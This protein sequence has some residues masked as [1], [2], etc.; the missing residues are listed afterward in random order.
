MAL[1]TIEEIVARRRMCEI[2]E[3]QTEII[4]TLTECFKENGFRW[5]LPVMLSFVTDPLWPE[6]SSTQITAPEVEIYGKKMKLM[7]SMILHKQIAVSMGLDRIFIL[8]PNIRVER[9]ERDDGHHAYEFTQ[10][11]FEI[12]HAKMGDVMHLV[13]EAVCRTASKVRKTVWDRFEREIPVFQRPFK[14]YT[15]EEV[16]KDY[17]S[18]RELSK[19]S[20]QPFWITDISREFYDKEDETRPGH[21]LNYD[22]VMPEGY[23]EVLSGGEREH[24]YE[25]IMTKLQRSNLSPSS[26]WPYLE[27][28]RKGLLK[29]SAGAGIG[30]ERLVRYFTGRQHIEDVQVFPRV[31]GVPAVV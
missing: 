24:E 19:V 23:G 11:D 8:S 6:P 31:P 21:C 3:V 29:P 30:I 20:T 22:L 17:G 25:K 15:M 26:F 1:R 18:D 16:M 28:A 12:A 5:M 9:P 10:L 2:M 13:E 4:H 27:I 7:H 14:V